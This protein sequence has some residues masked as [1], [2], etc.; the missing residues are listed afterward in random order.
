MQR[1]KAVLLML[2]LAGTVASVSAQ[3]CRTL[4][5][6]VRTLQVTANGDWLL[7]TVIE[8]GT[9][10]FVTV[11]FDYLSHEYHRFVWH[12]QHC[13]ADWT[14]S[15]LYEVDWLDGFNDRPI[16]YYENSLNTSVLY[17]HYAVDFPND[18]V[19]LKLSGNY[20]ITIYDERST[21]TETVREPVAEAFFRIVEPRVEITATVSGNTDIDTYA[22]HQQVS[23][24][25]RHDGYPILYPDTELSV[26]VVQND[27]PDAVV[28]GLK[29]SYIT[30]GR[31]DFFHDHRLI[32]LGSNEFRRFE[33]INMHYGNQGV[34]DVTYYAPYFHAELFADARRRAYSYDEDH[35]GR[36]L[37]RYNMA[38]DDDTEADYFFAHFALDMPYALDGDY[39]VSGAFSHG[40]PLPEYRMT[41]NDATRRYEAAALLK[42]GAYDYQYLFVPTGSPTPDAIRSPEGNFYETENEYAIYV[43]HRP[44]GDRYDHLVGFLRLE[45]DE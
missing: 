3:T 27:R 25:I 11:S 9:D 8:L 31:L 33:L 12:L 41:Y 38:D 17:T 30:N 43:Y 10:D 40:L 42:Q 5:P 37:V 23:F 7:P 29:P 14:P 28:G 18:D 20:R 32:F 44:F 13:N 6:M 19:V 39:Y 34:S 24:S 2:L 4:T 22:D 1:L 45:K 16:D 15:D 35:N 26:F 36:L 21:D